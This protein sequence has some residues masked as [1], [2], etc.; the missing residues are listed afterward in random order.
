MKKRPPLWYETVIH[1]AGH[2]VVA[3]LV[4]VAI[5]HVTIVPGRWNVGH[6]AA[7]RDPVAAEADRLWDE[8]KAISRKLVRGRLSGGFDGKEGWL[9]RKGSWHR[10]WKYNGRTVKR[11]NDGCGMR[12]THGT[13]APELGRRMER[14][15]KQAEALWKEANASRDHVKDLM[16]TLGG[17]V[18]DA[19]FF[20]VPFAAPRLRLATK[21]EVR[22]RGLP[23]IAHGSAK[24]PVG[25]YTAGGDF[26]MMRRTL[27]RIDD[28]PSRK[29]TLEHYRSR[30]EQLVRQHRTT[31]ARVAKALVKRKTL[32]GAELAKL[33]EGRP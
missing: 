17:P 19:V 9:L 29:E 8:A 7:V 33:I 18:A 22:A 20:N 6:S 24:T 1:E 12:T 2:A 32:S 15:R 21:E 3:H 13:P 27:K 10:Y 31:I 25:N 14:L 28:S 23:A 30:C 26:Q 16:H 4:G 5:D 11:S